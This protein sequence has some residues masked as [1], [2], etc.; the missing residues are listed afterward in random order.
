[1][2]QKKGGAASGS[3][4]SGPAVRTVPV[5]QRSVAAGFPLV[6]PEMGPM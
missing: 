1:M 4:P 2:K 5:G 6:Y 3:G